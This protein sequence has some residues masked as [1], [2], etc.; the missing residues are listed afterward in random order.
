MSQQILAAF[1]DDLISPAS[2]W[3][4]VL[5][6]ARIN[7]AA[8]AL[9]SC[10]QAAD[11]R[12]QRAIAGRGRV[13]AA[14][15]PLGYLRDLQRRF[16]ELVLADIQARLTRC[17]IF[18]FGKVL[19]E[20]FDTPVEQVPP[21]WWTWLTI[22]IARESVSGS[23]LHY[24]Y[25]AFA[26]SGHS[27]FNDL[28]DAVRDLLPE[29]VWQ[30]ARAAGGPT[31]VGRIDQML[32]VSASWQTMLPIMRERAACGMRLK[33]SKAEANALE[34]FAK[35]RFPDRPRPAFSTIRKHLAGVYRWIAVNG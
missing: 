4:T 3:N 22:D 29:K 32:Q 8:A 13:Q 7:D 12:A 35:E 5:R 2:L 21:D 34:A 15:T 25:V 31:T 9:A 24:A 23:T 11:R 18:G 26:I 30:R 19:P 20:T 33:G 1:R 17:E 27:A 16:N 6:E 14:L 10:L 28:H